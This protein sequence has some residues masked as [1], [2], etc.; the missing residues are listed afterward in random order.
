MV[1]R[2]SAL[3]CPGVPWIGGE[4]VLLVAF[5]V[6]C[7]ILCFLRVLGA[8]AVNRFEVRLSFGALEV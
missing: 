6:P 2:E 8:F 4:H 5:P 1:L 3:T 7:L